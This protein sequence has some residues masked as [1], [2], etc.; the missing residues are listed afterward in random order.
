MRNRCALSA[1]ALAALLFGT[2]SCAFA[3]LHPSNQELRAE[4]HGR[5]VDADTG[6]GIPEANVIAI[7]RQHSS[8]VS[9]MVSAGT[10]CNLQRIMVTDAEGRFVVPDVSRELDERELHFGALSLNKLW[11]DWL[12]IVFKPGYVRVGDLETLAKHDREFFSW[13]VEPPETQGRPGK[14]DVKP[15]AMKKVELDAPKVWAY[16]GVLLSSGGCNDSHGKRLNEP[17]Y[18]EIATAMSAQVRSMPCAMPASTPIDANSF[19]AF[20][21]LS[22]PGAFDVKFYERVKKLSGLPPSERFDPL[23]KVSTTA[24][25]LCQAVTDEEKRQ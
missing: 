15:T 24:G 8:G 9:D 6:T 11:S 19:G 16:Y 13:Q 12:L 20:V 23:E 14:L 18:G 7:W 5:I 3:P 17:A 22:H 10:W 25:A 4:K 2:A 21:G 1:C